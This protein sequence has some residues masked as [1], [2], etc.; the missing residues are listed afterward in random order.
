MAAPALLDLRALGGQERSAGFLSG[1]GDAA[2]A[3][4]SGAVPS[5]PRMVHP[6]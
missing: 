6:L 3:E 5:G 4:V 2:A 1:L